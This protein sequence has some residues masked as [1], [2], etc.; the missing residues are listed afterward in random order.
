[1]A[2]EFLKG[3]GLIRSS[4]HCGSCGQDMTWSKRPDTGNEQ[5]GESLTPDFPFVQ[6][7]RANDLRSTSQSA[8]GMVLTSPQLLLVNALRRRYKIGGN[9]A[10]LLTWDPRLPTFTC[11]HPTFFEI[12]SLS[13]C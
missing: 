12:Y 8:E 9:Q 4:M 13:T 3:T 2:S 10:L 5:K 7:K 11:L 6:I 1:M